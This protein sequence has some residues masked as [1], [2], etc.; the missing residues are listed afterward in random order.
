MGMAITRNPD[1]TKTRLDSTIKSN[2][3][4]KCCA[5]SKANTRSTELSLKVTLVEVEFQNSIFF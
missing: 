4:L 2:R 1:L 5:D 3:G